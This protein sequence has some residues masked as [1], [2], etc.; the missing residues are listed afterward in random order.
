MRVH[1]PK[2][3]E[4]K[5]KFINYELYKHNSYIANHPLRYLRNTMW[6]LY[7]S[8]SFKYACIT[9]VALNKWLI[10]IKKWGFQ[11]KINKLVFA[12]KIYIFRKKSVF[13]HNM[14]YQ[15][16]FIFISFVQ[17]V[18]TPASYHKYITKR[19]WR[20]NWRMEKCG[21]NSKVMKNLPIKYQL[22]FIWIR[23]IQIRQKNG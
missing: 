19:I 22:K 2:S 7:L 9:E 10:L 3:Y 8:A 13:H 5:E 18:N 23:Y 11:M 15:V 12:D 14:N 6:S 21:Q 1:I 4:L 16:R 17:I 20:K